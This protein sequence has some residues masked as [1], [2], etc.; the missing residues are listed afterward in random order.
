ME[1]NNCE[2]EQR[3]MEV[4][5]N[6][7]PLIAQI[8]DEKS[9][10]R[11]VCVFCGSSTGKKQSYQD[12]AVELGAELVS[13]LFLQFDYLVS[14]SACVRTFCFLDL[15]GVEENRS[16][17]RRRKRGA[18]GSCLAGRSPGWG[19]C[20]WVGASIIPHLAVLPSAYDCSACFVSDSQDH[21]ADVN[22]KGGQL[23]FFTLY[24]CFHFG[25]I[26]FSLGNRR[27]GGG[28]EGCGRDAP[29]E[30]GNVSPFR[31]IHR[32]PR[33]SFSLSPLSSS[34]YLL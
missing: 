11:S 21:S 27:D 20:S 34:I 19:S 14:S 9:P 18:D 17:L 15:I 31:R 24:H 12:A 23:V 22:E 3:A 10:F 29:E 8:P 1:P 7:A 25:L 28:G 16:G 30:G 4:T 5:A 33:F 32:S 6:S 26:S 13:L 2:E